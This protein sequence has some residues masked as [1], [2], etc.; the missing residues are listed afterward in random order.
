MFLTKAEWKNMLA[1]LEALEDRATKAERALD[2]AHGWGRSYPGLTSKVEAIE[3]ELQIVA[4]EYAYGVRGHYNVKL[5]E[6][7]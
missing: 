2:D 3:R 6:P 4:Y 1:R 5:K 7:A